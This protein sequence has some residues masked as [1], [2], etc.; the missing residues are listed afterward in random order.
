MNACEYEI[1]D[2]PGKLMRWGVSASA[3]DPETGELMH[4][5]LLLSAALCAVLDQQPWSLPGGFVVQAA[6]PMKE[7]D[8]G[9]F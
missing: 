8:A 9:R 7:I 3:R 4:D 1:L 6:D 5:D 2:G